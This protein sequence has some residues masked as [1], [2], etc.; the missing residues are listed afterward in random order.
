MTKKKIANF[1]PEITL[2]GTD[3]SLSLYYIFS[4]DSF[5]NSAALWNEDTC[6]HWPVFHWVNLHSSSQTLL[7][8]IIGSLLYH[9][10]HSWSTPTSSFQKLTPYIHQHWSAKSFLS[11]WVADLRKDDVIHLLYHFSNDF[12][13]YIY[14]WFILWLASVKAAADTSYVFPT[15]N[16]FLWH[17]S[18]MWIMIPFVSKLASNYGVLSFLSPLFS[19]G[20]KASRES[21]L[22]FPIRPIY[23]LFPFTQLPHP[24]YPAVNS[25]RAEEWP[26]E[27]SLPCV[28]LHNP[29]KHFKLLLSNKDDKYLL[30]LDTP[31]GTFIF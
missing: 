28:E 3:S 12:K 16:S 26:V 13:R 29:G 18:T 4:C 10:T 23:L 31:P 19:N 1:A 30:S 7:N 27:I 2:E 15:P 11:E 14:I 20:A 9:F 22:K 25:C 17:V 5:W 8:V 21:S 6:K 24:Y